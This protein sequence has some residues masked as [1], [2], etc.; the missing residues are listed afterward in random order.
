MMQ[1]Y[2]QSTTDCSTSNELLSTLNPFYKTTH[3]SGKWFENNV[4]FSFVQCANCIKMPMFGRLFGE[5]SPQTELNFS[6]AVLIW[7]RL[8]FTKGILSSMSF[9]QSQQFLEGDTCWHYLKCS[10]IGMWFWHTARA[11]GITGTAESLTPFIVLRKVQFPQRK[12]RSK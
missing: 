10:I 9:S 12:S 4:W 11:Y 5:E 8:F 2:V 3:Y 7:T 1:C 6:L